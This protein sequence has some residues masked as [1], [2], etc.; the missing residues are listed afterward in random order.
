MAILRRNDVG[1]PNLP[2]IEEYLGQT[3][4]DNDDLSFRPS[5]V[6]GLLDRVGYYYAVAGETTSSEVAVSILGRNTDA[7]FS[8]LFK[9]FTTRPA[10]GN[11]SIDFILRTLADQPLDDPNRFMKAIALA[12]EFN[13]QAGTLTLTEINSWFLYHPEGMVYCT[14]DSL[15][16]GT[17]YSHANNEEPFIGWYKSE[18][19]SHLSA[20]NGFYMDWKNS[21][22]SFYG[23]TTCR[24][25]VE[26]LMEKPDSESCDLAVGSLTLEQ[27]KG[28]VTCPRCQANGLAL[29]SWLAHRQP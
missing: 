17:L 12:T 21:C 5:F 16:D 8:R 4:L 15:P 28:E 25:P 23:M 19:Q 29:V 9:R 6:L 26:E 13:T 20:N 11:D 18:G 27:V 22:L 7:P 3:W 2:V 24:I 10:A 1:K 14:A